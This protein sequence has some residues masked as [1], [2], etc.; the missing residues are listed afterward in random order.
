MT[1]MWVFR[2]FLLNWSSKD[3]GI[4]ARLNCTWILKEHSNL[5]FI[6]KSI[7]D[8]LNCHQMDGKLGT[9]QFKSILSLWKSGKA[10]DVPFNADNVRKKS[11]K[12]SLDDFTGLMSGSF[13][14]SRWLWVLV[15]RFV[16]SLRLYLCGWFYSRSQQTSASWRPSWT[17][18]CRGRPQCRPK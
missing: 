8:L 6:A 4:V 5:L 16:D 13:S 15:W 9:C 7:L 14:R 12:W 3:M 1:K 2:M 11:T 18:G 17:C 10:W